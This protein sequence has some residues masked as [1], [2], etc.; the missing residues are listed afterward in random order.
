MKT[1]NV[2][3]KLFRLG[4]V[5]SSVMFVFCV[6]GFCGGTVG[7]VSMATGAPTLKIGGVTLRSILKVGEETAPGA[8]YAAMAAAMIL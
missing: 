3:Q 7:I 8:V 4:K 1:L 2:I 5:L 6:V